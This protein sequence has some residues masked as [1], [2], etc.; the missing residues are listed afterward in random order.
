MEK[1]REGNRNNRHNH[2]QQKTGDGRI[3][4]IEDSIDEIDTFVKENVKLTKFLTQN[5]EEIWGIKTR[6]K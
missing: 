6:R 2:H 3:S 1:P 5:I 4:G